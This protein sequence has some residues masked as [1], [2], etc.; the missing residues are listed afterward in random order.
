MNPE[1]MTNEEL[2]RYAMSRGSGTTV[3][4]LALRLSDALDKLD[5]LQEHEDNHR[6]LEEEFSNMTFHVDALKEE[7]IR[8]VEVVEDFLPNIGKCVLQDYGRLNEFLIESKMLLR[9]RT[10]EHP[11]V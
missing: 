11:P 3:E 8:G 5:E 10:Y 9:G 1:N 7:L 4:I 2:I 6:E